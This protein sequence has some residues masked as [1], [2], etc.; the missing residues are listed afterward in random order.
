MLSAA[1]KRFVRYWEEQRKG[2]F[3][4]YFLLYILSGTLVATIVLY[5][6]LNMFTVNFAG[7]NWLIPSCSFVGIGFVTFFTWKKNEQRLK[8]LIRR[9]VKRGKTMDETNTGD[10]PDGRNAGRESLN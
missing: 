1:E 7:K 3:W 6:L 9:E 5:F 4:P 8:G 2:G 10:A